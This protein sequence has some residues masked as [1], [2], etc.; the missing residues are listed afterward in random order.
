MLYKHAIQLYKLFNL[1][2]PP[3]DWVALNF[4]QFM[5]SRQTRFVI[6]TNSNYKVGNNILSNRLSILN[7]KIDLTWLNDGLSTFKIRCKKLLLWLNTTVLVHFVI[8][9][10]LQV[11]QCS[12]FFMHQNNLTIWPRWGTCNHIQTWLLLIDVDALATDLGFFV[13]DV[14]AIGQSRKQC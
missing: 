1:H 3:Q 12:H 13:F 14:T 7:H 10:L 2:E 6:S 9:I 4:F 5:S 11:K 8:N